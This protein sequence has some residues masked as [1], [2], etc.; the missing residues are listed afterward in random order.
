MN[1]PVAFIIFNRPDVTA[2]VF[3]VIRQVRPVKLFLI[4]DGP[5][6]E[7]PEDVELC[8][9]A[10]TVVENVDW[11]CELHKNYSDVNLGCGKRPATGISWLFEH[12]EKAIILEDDCLP[13]P[14][15][16][17]YCEELL[18]KYQDDQR[19]MHIA[20]NNRGFSQDRSGYSYYYSLLPYCWGWATWRRAWK[21]YDFDFQGLAEVING[22]LFNNLLQDRKAA[23]YWR[24]RFCDL[25][26]SSREDIWDF[27]WTF[28]CWL[29]NGLA[30]VP[31]ENL[32]RNIGFG[33]D[34]THTKE[35][36]LRIT[37]LAEYAIEDAPDPSLVHSRGICFSISVPL[38]I[39][40]T[41]VFTGI[42]QSG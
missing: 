4:A 42:F 8:R 36:D 6:S 11:P 18:C 24:Q 26:R 33:E 30:I 28:A 3:D 15:F 19:I 9:A 12:V 38:G 17:L 41:V 2:K 27:Q 5:R 23:K 37:K 20:G 31:N 39:L 1:T 10:R 21:Y 13:H 22:E 34:A 35:A 16:F 40:R 32:V 7:V 14:S 25:K 29:N